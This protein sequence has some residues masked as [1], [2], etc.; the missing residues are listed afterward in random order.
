MTVPSE[1]QWTKRGLWNEELPSSDLDRLSL[2]TMMVAPA[3]GESCG[4]PEP[5][6]AQ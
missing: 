1:E 3:Q 2:G 5:G 4:K 6:E